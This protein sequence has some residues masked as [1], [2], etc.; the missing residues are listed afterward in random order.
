MS[1]NSRTRMRTTPTGSIEMLTGSGQGAAQT[2]A[3]NSSIAYAYDD[4]GSLSS[5]RDENH[6]A[7]NT[8]YSYDA[9]RRLASVQ[10]S[11]SGSNVTTAYS[12]DAAGNLATVTDP[13]GNV[14]S[15][16]YDD[17]G[18]MTL[19]ISPITGATAYAYGNSGELLSTTDATGASTTRTYDALNRVLTAVSSRTGQSDE[20]VNWSYDS[21]TFALGRLTY[22]SD[23]AGATTYAYDRRGLL[24]S[25]SR[26]SGAVLLATS[27]KY[28]ANGNRT[29]ITYP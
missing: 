14:T 2:H 8:H 1:R 22:I 17:F 3:D 24:L 15:Y 29:A 6:A 18:E 12:Y 4:A 13:N 21:G 11:L 26:T 25:E 28:D 27:F 16:G 10:Q 23:P 5:I 9:A 7:A 20:R 19:Q